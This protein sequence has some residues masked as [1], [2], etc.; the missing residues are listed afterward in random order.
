LL[1]IPVEEGANL[2]SGGKWHDPLHFL[3]SW[4]VKTV[5][6]VVWFC[7]L[8]WDF[9]FYGAWGISVRNMTV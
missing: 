8:T 5:Y 7:V 4:A 2:K 9:A 3:V 1:V 6:T